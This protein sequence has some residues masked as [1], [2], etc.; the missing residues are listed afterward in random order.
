M[1]ASED[2][3]ENPIGLAAAGLGVVVHCSDPGVAMALERGYQD[4]PLGEAADLSLEVTLTGRERASPLLDTGTFFKDGVLH[5]SAPGYQGRIQVPGGTGELLL[6]SAHPVEDIDYALRVAYALLAFQAGGVMLHAAGIVR[7]GVAYLFTG[8]SGSGK[9]TVARLSVQDTVLNDDLVILLPGGSGWQVHGTPFSNPTQV[10][11][12]ARRA[13]LGGLY[14]L[15]QARCVKIE[16]LSSSLAV[17]ELVANVPVIPQDPG[18]GGVL[19]ERL[20]EIHRAAALKKL[21]FTPDGSFW[22]LIAPQGA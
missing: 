22:D 11:P 19:L 16:R 7:A 9:T 13:P 18:R 14:R 3:R 6:S 21:Y 12:R 1:C 10:A 15:V 17:A 4:F 8:H 20:G 2:P 5:F